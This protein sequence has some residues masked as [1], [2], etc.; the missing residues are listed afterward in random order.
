MALASLR[1]DAKNCDTFVL[2]IFGQGKLIRGVSL[3]PSLTAVYTN[4]ILIVG[5]S[6]DFLDASQAL[7][8]FEDTV[9]NHG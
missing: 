1:F 3:T 4:F 2:K 6:K 7:D 9:L 5:H 8:G